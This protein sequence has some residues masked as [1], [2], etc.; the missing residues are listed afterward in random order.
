MIAIID[1]GMGNPGSIKN[2]LRKLGVASQ[3]TSDP[4]TIQ[5]ASKLILPGVGAFDAGMEHLHAKGLVGL[6]DRRVKEERVPVLGICLG[7]QLMTRSSE[8]GGKPGLGW[9]DAEARRFSVPP[10]SRLKVPH[11]GWAPV[12]SQKPS[13]LVSAEGVDELRFYFVHSYYVSCNNSDDIALQASHGNDFVAGFE[14]DN[15]LGVQFH[16]EKSHKFGLKLLENFV[17]RF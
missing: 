8:E 10:A 1:Y 4:Q 7:M 3:I 2:M 6:L 13:K 16:P 5:D 15:I 14:H 9:I 11:M 17:T 12:T